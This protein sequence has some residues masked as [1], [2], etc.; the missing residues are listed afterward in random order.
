MTRALVIVCNYNNVEELPDFLNE[1]DRFHP[2][3]DV[4]VV[5]DGSTDESGKLAE[6]KGYKVLWHGQ[7]RGVGAAIRTGLNHARQNKEYDS[8]VIMAG[9]GKMK[10]R[11]IAQVLAPV[12]E[13]RA[14][15]VQGNRY[16]GQ[17][18]KLTWFRRVAIPLFS[19]GVSVLLR[20]WIADAS[21]GF[22]SLKLEMLQNPKIDLEQEWLDRYD[23]E[24]YLLYKACRLD[25]R[26]VEAPVTMDY[27]HLSKGRKSK[28]I[29][30]VGWWSMIRPFVYLSFGVKK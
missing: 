27:S 29:P 4:V 19:F 14:D 3:Q 1:M 7:N 30:V 16:L 22:R 2:K 13:G 9:N 10:P 26:I 5:D 23:L 17:S 15:L 28:I 18:V 8:A 6:G 21:C 12:R 24:Y 25:Y 20:R 11:E